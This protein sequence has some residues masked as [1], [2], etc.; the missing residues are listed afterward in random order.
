MKVLAIS[1]GSKNGSNDAM[2]REALMGAKEAG[3]EIEFIRLHDLNLKPCTGCIACV[4]NL[5]Q[6]G[7]G[8]CVLKDD[9]KW[10]EN[11]VLD[12]DG[13]IFVMPIFEKGSPGIMHVLQDRLCGPSHDIGINFVA[14]KIAEKEGKPGPDP[15]KFKKKAVSFISIGGSDWNTRVSADMNLVA[16]TA[17]WKVIDDIVFAWAKSIVLDD[18]KV[19]TCHRVG[20]NIAKAAAD[21]DN[22]RYLGDPGVCPLCHSRNFFLNSDGMAV[23]EVCGMTGELSKVDGKFVFTVEPG[24]YD[25]AHTLLPGKLKHMDDIYHYETRLAEQKKT[26]EYKERIK[27]YVAFISASKPEQKEDIQ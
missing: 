20:V 16:M 7:N 12:A 27:K 21:I 5:M 13:I 26:P 17:S 9:F 18:E 15:R 19:A 2:A 8:D 14:Q 6:G 10:L 11:K 25:L 22:A 24:Q 1:G 23:C 3:A 4:N